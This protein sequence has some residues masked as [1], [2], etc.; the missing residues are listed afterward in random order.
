MNGLIVFICI[1]TMLTNLLIVI[2]YY[3]GQNRLFLIKKKRE[4][5]IIW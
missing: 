4:N 2:N 1:I 5:E 3:K